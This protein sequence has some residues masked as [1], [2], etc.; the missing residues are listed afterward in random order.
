MMNPRIEAEL[1]LLRRHYEQVDYLAANAMHWFRV[2]FLIT[3]E[4]WSPDQVP[5]V[6][7][8]GEG[9]PGAQPY[10]FYV[11]VE[12]MLNGAAPSEHK[13]PHQP[14]FEGKWR[15]LSWQPVGWNPQSDVRTGSNLWG[16]VRSFIGRLKEGK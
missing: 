11:P 4:C 15:F 14:P 10:G 16:W 3:P 5:V 9:H 6:F 7:A 1:R 13:A 2:Q 12:L 8:V